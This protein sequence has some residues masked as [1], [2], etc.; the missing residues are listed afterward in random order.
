MR[1]I[2]AGKFT[3]RGEWSHPEFTLDSCDTELIIVTEG[4]FEMSVGAEQFSLQPGSVL[5]IEP[6]KKHRGIGVSEE[7]VSF[8]WLHF[9]PDA[10][11]AT[12]SGELKEPY[13]AILLCRQILHYQE[14]ISAAG[15]KLTEVLLL[16]ILS[17]LDGFEPATGLAE[18]VVEWV[19]INS[20]RALEIADVT[21][22]FG[23]SE[24]YLTRLP[25]R[26]CGLGLKQLISEKRMNHLK[27]Q[28]LESEMTLTEIADSSGFSDVK[29]FLKYFAYHES[30]TPT[31]FRKLYRTGHTNN[32]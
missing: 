19:R 28:L 26:S 15:E 4:C 18:R 23:Y 7:R 32:R 5:F 9:E 16:E 6:S 17:Q 12:R 14:S 31:E 3:S 22:R 20:D 2:N 10:P 13:H 29:L 24:D 1:F 21:E 25:R 27:K 11:I 30:I 8:Y